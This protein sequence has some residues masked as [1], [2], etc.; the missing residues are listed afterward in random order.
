MR[1][2]LIAALC[3]VPLAACS[4]SAS[5]PFGSLGSLNPFGGRE[6][7]PVIV[8]RSDGVIRDGRSL[9]PTLDEV[10][11]EPALRGLILRARA[12]APTQGFYG[13]ALV[14][15]RKGEPDENG[16]VTFQFRAVPPEFAQPI[17]PAQTRILLAAA[18]IEDADLEQI[19]GFRIVTQGRTI[20]LRR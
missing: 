13:A 15:E 11:P 20:S 5:N 19:R 3:V 16:I 10:V 6:E 12:T 18:F 1:Q 2:F 7:E 9:L 8:A 17:G 14:P 4:G